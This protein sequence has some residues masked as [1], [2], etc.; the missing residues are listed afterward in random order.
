MKEAT[1]GPEAALVFYQKLLDADPSNLVCNSD[2]VSVAGSLSCTMKAVWKRQISVLNRL[3]RTENAVDEL[4]KLVDTF[5]TDVE[6]WLQLADLYISLYQ[7]VYSSP[8]VHVSMCCML[9]T[10]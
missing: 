3:G 1:E 10:I 8:L 6:A 9:T 4:S 5:Y 2:L 7:Y